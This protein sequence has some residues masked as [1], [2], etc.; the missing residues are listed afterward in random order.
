MSI[1]IEQ[2]RGNNDYFEDFITRSTYHSTH[3]EGNTLTYGETYSIIF[4]K[5][6]ILI[7]NAKPR[8][9]YE[10]INHKIALDYMM[11]N[12]DNELSLEVIRH[13]GVLLNKNISEISDFRGI[14]V[15]IKG[16]EYL[17]PPPEEVRMQLYYLLDSYNNSEY[18]DIFERAA[19]FHIRFERIHPFEDGNGRTGRL[20]V[21]YDFL[22]NDYLPIVIPFESRGEYFEVLAKQDISALSAMFKVFYDNEIIRAKQ[23]GIDNKYNELNDNKKDKY[24][25]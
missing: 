7:N 12:V 3:I 17:P 21:N 11:N 9:L 5:N 19:D 24:S 20:L 14:P 16:A 13:I 15:Y 10:A 8:D 23:F 18:T 2:I 6:D 22:R 1:I 25:R 4:N